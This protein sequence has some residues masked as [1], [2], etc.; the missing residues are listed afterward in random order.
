MDCVT[1][2]GWNARSSIRKRSNF[3]FPSFSIRINPHLA[4]INLNKKRTIFRLDLVYGKTFDKNIWTKIKHVHIFYKLVFIVQIP[5]TKKWL[6]N[7]TQKNHMFLMY[8]HNYTFK[9]YLI[10][11]NGFFDNT[12]SSFLISVLISI[13]II[14]KKYHMIFLEPKS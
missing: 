13:K 2:R 9:R 4:E 7:Y 6:L 11:V 5:V 10:A 1:G 8:L 14:L 3:E 12:V